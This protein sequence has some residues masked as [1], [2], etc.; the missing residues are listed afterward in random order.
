LKVH[1]ELQTYV[2]ALSKDLTPARGA[3]GKSQREKWEERVIKWTG[4]AT[5]QSIELEFK[6]WSETDLREMLLREENVSL[7]KYWFGRDVLND[8]WFQKQVNLGIRALEDRFNPDHHV[9]VTV[10][11]LF[12]TLARGRHITEQITDGFNEIQK[13]KIPNIEFSSVELAPDA[14]VLLQANKTWNE[15]V[16]FKGVVQRSFNQKWDTNSIIRVLESLR[17]SV[18]TFERQYSLIDKDELDDKID[19][20]KLDSTLVSLRNISF[21]IDSLND[22]LRHPNLEAEAQQCAVIHGPAGAGK[23]HILGQVAE[24]RVSAGLPTVLL[25]GQSFS[26]SVFWEQLGALL[27]LEGKTADDVLGMLNAAGE[28]IGQRTLLLFDAI[29]EGVGA[30]YWRQNL[31]DFFYAI[32]KYPYLA[33]VFSCREEY[34]PYAFPDSLTAI[35]PKFRISG[36]STSKELEQAAIRYLDSKGIARPNT[37]WLSPEFSNPL[38]LKSASEALHAKGLKEF[39]RG[40]NGISKIMVLYLDALSW[41]IGVETTNFSAISTS[42]KQC[43]RLIANKM[44]TDGCDYV[45]LEQA[46]SLAEESF[47]GRTSPEG[48]T[49]LDVL[50]EASLFR[51]DPPPYSK[52]VDPFNPPSELVRFAFQR[53]QDHLM[54]MA[55]VEKLTKEQ[56]NIAFDDDGPLN[57]LF[58]SGNLDHGFRYEYTGLVSALSTVYPEKLELEFAKTLPNWEQLWQDE[59]VLQEGFGES[60]KWRSPDAFSD[61]TGELLNRLDDHYVEPLGLLLEVSMSVEHPFNALRLHEHL[62]QYS[63][64]ERDSHW[65]R[66]I[67]WASREEF[68]QI[69]R[70]V[71]WALSVSEGMADVK[72][73]ELASL[74]LAW[75]LSSS[76]MT[77]RDRA[78]KA[79]TNLFLSNAV[80]FIYVLDKMYDCDDPYVIERLYAAA[81][82]ACCIDQ[83]SERLATY[84]R[85]TYAKVF[86][87]RK[88][89]VALLSRDYAL[90][91][92]ELADVKGALNDEVILDDC[93]HPFKSDAPMFGLNKEEIEAAADACG[94]KEIFNSASSEWGDYGK[95]SIPG[96]V[97]SFLTTKL[98]QPKPISKKERKHRFVQ[99]VIQPHSEPILAL[100]EFEKASE[101]ASMAVFLKFTEDKGQEEGS[102][103]EEKN[104]ALHRLEKLLNEDEITRLNTEYFG[105][106]DHEEFKKIDVRQCRLWITKRAYELGWNSK[107]FAR[108]GYGTG[109][110]R[111]ENDLERIGKKY[112]RIALDELQARLADHY[113]ALQNW[114]AKP[115][116]YRYSHQDFRRNLEPTILPLKDQDTT[117][118]S[119]SEHWM[120]E[121]NLKLPK[122]DEELLKQWP[123]DEDPTQLMAE[124]LIRVDDK[125]NSWLVLYEF[126]IDGQK[127][128]EPCPGEHGLR[129]EEFRF[130][131]CVFVKRGKAR[132]LA[133]HL[134]LELTLDVH[135]FQPAEFTDGPYL[136]EAHWRETWSTQDNYD[137]LSGAPEG[138]EYTIP[139]CRYLWE[140]HLDKS[141]PNGFSMFMPQKWFADKLKVSMSSS[142]PHQWLNNLGHIVVQTNSTSEEKNAVIVDES[143]LNSYA[144][145]NGIEPVWL[146]IAERNSFPNGSNTEFCGRRAEGVVWCENGEW[147]QLGWNKDSKH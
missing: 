32:K 13:S 73:M 139:I 2:F 33:A 65:T 130:F 77:L 106:G 136:R 46:T 113:W 50:I 19:K 51:R 28:R 71:S 16:E 42:I 80:S 56:A 11:S 105:D 89:P 57:F 79:L 125:G 109:Y 107:L 18:W 112:Q 9:T 133:E 39:P 72:H 43:V 83:S 91:I 24:Q 142:H 131:Y 58:Y 64:P 35:L 49:W 67:N 115:C 53:F 81:F 84:S 119:H 75:S 52:D 59:Q 96:R 121:P 87:Y 30:L 134:K 41:R 5:D 21:A 128:N 8:S 140:S 92:I 147:K 62:K 95:Y 118:H 68:S 98:E 78:T 54:A 127:Y 126:N 85:I 55:L 14:G 99:D 34:L 104:N 103:K 122:V 61:S 45:E 12:D 144:E 111:H 7:V 44:A 48:K 94:G 90:G 70:V 69:D 74:V 36:F 88:P 102:L 3:Q 101:A 15:L 23:S 108:D 123:F 6:L 38:F 47:K 129:Y 124:K 114:P 146:M 110:S 66:W 37:P 135:S 63:M 145:D 31:T 116:I 20:S 4:W 25:L 137:S 86:A 97:G 76:H 1:P 10:E 82:G 22:T 100:E 93:Y 27:G 120:T 60:F 117:R 26:S 143:I 17:K 132:E 40:L 138:C 141:L 29:N